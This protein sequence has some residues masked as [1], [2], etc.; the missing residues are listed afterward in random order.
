[1]QKVYD[2]VDESDPVWPEFEKWLNKY[3]AKKAKQA[4]QRRARVWASTDR[5]ESTEW[6]RC[7]AKQKV[8]LKV[9]DR[10][11]NWKYI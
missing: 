4:E 5:Q 11:E 9:L 2:P 7:G 1:M 3:N 8:F 6:S 10:R